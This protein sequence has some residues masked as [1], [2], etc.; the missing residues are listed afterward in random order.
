MPPST[1]R[2][3]AAKYAHVAQYRDVPQAGHWMIGEPGWERLAAGC[4][5]WV[6]AV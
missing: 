3:T 4:A 1:V 5:D 2:L 6:A